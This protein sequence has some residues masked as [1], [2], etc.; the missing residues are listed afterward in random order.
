MGTT[1]RAIVSMA[2]A[3]VMAWGGTS[4]IARVSEQKPFKTQYILGVNFMPEWQ[5]DMR[6]RVM[7][8][9][10][11]AKFAPNVGISFEARITRHSG[12][13][14]GFYY[15]NVKYAGGISLADPNVRY[16]SSYSRYFSIPVLYK[17]YS[18]ILNI[19]AGMNYDVRFGQSE[20]SPGDARNRFGFIVQV[21]KDITLGK[22][23]FLEPE[24][25]F[26]PFV[27][28]GDWDNA[29]LGFQIGLKYRF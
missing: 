16:S 12:I 1:T 24:F 19:G 17:Y 20:N 18:R 28:D 2:A 21:G 7:G 26:N 6:G 3:S 9:G 8:G 15:R 27:D 11:D 22:G 5:K 10:S 23:L 29:W 14:T 25:H 4:A 13:E